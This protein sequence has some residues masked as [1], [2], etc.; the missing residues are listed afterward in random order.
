MKRFLD[1][2]TFYKTTEIFAIGGKVNLESS[3]G[4]S[5]SLGSRGRLR[6]TD[7]EL[8]GRSA[9]LCAL[10]LTGRCAPVDLER[11]AGDGVPAEEL[12]GTGPQPGTGLLPESLVLQ[13][14]KNAVGELA[15][16]LTVRI[17]INVDGGVTQMVRK[18]GLAG[19][20]N[21]KR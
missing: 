18:S 15:N 7:L 9:G 8:E 2:N 1:E 19:A 14:F 13:Q 20:D 6:S 21:G 4:Q 17:G 5:K 3:V 12:F 10:T 16:Y 11:L